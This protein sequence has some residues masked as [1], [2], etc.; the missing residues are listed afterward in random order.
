VLSRTLRE[1]VDPI[2]HRHLNDLAPFADRVPTPAVIAEWV[3]GQLEG[4]LPGA[5]I[6]RIEVWTSATTYAGWEP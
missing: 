6:R 5:R 2:D 1:V 4:R 3:G